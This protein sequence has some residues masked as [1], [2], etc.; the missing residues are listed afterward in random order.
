MGGSCA[1]HCSSPHR[2]QANRGRARL[3]ANLGFS[4]AGTGRSSEGSSGNGGRF[5]KRKRARRR[6][7]GKFSRPAVHPSG[8]CSYSSDQRGRSGVG[9]AVERSGDGARRRGRYGT[10]T[11]A[12]RMDSVSAGCLSL[13]QRS[14]TSSGPPHRVNGGG[15]CFGSTIGRTSIPRPDERLRDGAATGCHPGS[16]AAAGGTVGAG[17]TERLKESGT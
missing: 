15:Q 11:A 3:L 12:E 6:A 17:A 5:R 1:A 7:G 13:G 9:P 2:N 16:Q 10:E 14:R 8:G 4:K